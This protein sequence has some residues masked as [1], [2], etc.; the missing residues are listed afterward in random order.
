MQQGHEKLKLS[1]YVNNIDGHRIIIRT[2]Q[3]LYL[4]LR[5]F[6][7]IKKKRPCKNIFNWLEKYI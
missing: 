7:I 6:Q 5:Q 2:F 4:S 1:D 3:E